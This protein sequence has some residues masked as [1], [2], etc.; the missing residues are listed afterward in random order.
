MK[1][2]ENIR[3]ILDTN[4]SYLGFIFYAA[5]KRNY[6]EDTLPNLPKSIRK[7]GVFVN[8]DIHTLLKKAKQFKLDVLQL[9]GDESVSYCKRVKAEGF[10]VFKVFGIKDQLPLVE[11]QTYQNVVDAF[12]FDTKGKERGGNGVLFDWSV[13]EAY[14][15][16][17]PIVLSGGI[18]IDAVDAIKDLKKKNL[19]LMAVDINSCFESAPGVKKYKEIKTFIKAIS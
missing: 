5:S 10:K 13:L 17:V 19:P 16:K 12:L 4:P 3:E 6:T 11:L 2:E 18:G 14:N 9:H 8:E 1:Y 7:V 15:L